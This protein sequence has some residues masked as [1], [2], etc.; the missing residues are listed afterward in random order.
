MI[1][2]WGEAVGELLENF[3]V[4]NLIVRVSERFQQ[5]LFSNRHLVKTLTAIEDSVENVMEVGK[6]PARG[7]G[8]LVEGMELASRGRAKPFRGSRPLPH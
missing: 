7:K 8:A 2:D 3:G 5:G 4:K 1:S 6:W